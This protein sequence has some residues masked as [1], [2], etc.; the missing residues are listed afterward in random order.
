MKWKNLI[1]WKRDEEHGSSQSESVAL[2]ERESDPFRAFQREM[3]RM[4][5]G[6]FDGSG[7]L[8]DLWGGRW[9]PETDVVVKDKEVVVSAELPGLNQDDLDIRV[10]GNA[11]TIRGEKKSETRN[12][13]GENVLVE[14]SYGSF[15]RRIPLP[16]AVRDDQAEASYKNGVLTIRLPR[17]EESTNGRRRIPVAG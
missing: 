14:R 6:F 11:L 9:F 7:E 17:R 10:S 8:N 13:E 16:A 1:P 3:N 15:E 4:M 2:A 5:E 12:E